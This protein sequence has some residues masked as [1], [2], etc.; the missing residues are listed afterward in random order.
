MVNIIKY[1]IVT[2]SQ[3]TKKRFEVQILF[4]YIFQKKN[5]FF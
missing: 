5:I 2:F 4:E 3:E 1:I